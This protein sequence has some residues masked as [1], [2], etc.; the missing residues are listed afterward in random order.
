MYWAGKNDN[1]EAIFLIDP[2]EGSPQQNKKPIH[3]KKISCS[4]D[5]VVG[6]A[7]DG[8]IYQV[9]TNPRSPIFPLKTKPLK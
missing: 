8:T 6:I 7:V 1:P 5:H 2:V 4:D 9:I 3:M